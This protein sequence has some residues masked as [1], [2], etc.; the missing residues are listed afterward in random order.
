MKNRH[1]ISIAGIILVLLSISCGGAKTDVS[2]KNLTEY[3]N[4]FIGTGDHGH[5]FLGA[6]VPFGMVQLGP[7]QIVKG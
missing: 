4:P 2:E 1:A 3:V 6:N 7:S 5:V